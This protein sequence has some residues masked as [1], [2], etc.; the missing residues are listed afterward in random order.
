V[1]VSVPP[2]V[3]EASLIE[4]LD[5]GPPGTVTTTVSASHI[6]SGSQTAR[7]NVSDAGRVRSVVITDAFGRS[8]EL[9]SSCHGYVA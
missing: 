8:A 7:S 3:A 6:A 4:I 9:D 1:K 2:S 5:P